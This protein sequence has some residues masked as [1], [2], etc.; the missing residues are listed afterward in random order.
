MS[1][2]S[3]AKSNKKKIPR[4]SAP[5]RR[6]LDM[7]NVGPDIVTVEVHAGTA[8]MERVV[9]M[10]SPV[11][12]LGFHSVISSDSKPFNSRNRNSPDRRLS[13][14][15]NRRPLQAANEILEIGIHGTFGSLCGNVINR[16]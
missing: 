8:H 6:S 15:P 11:G 16:E 4:P 1:L 9:R 13:Y 7:D 12:V 10:P 14:K 5:P 3:F 2:T